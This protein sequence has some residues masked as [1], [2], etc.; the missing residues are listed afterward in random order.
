MEEIRISKETLYL[1]GESIEDAR[2]RSMNEGYEP[3]DTPHDAWY[4]LPYFEREERPGDY[5]V[6]EFVTTTEITK[7]DP[8]YTRSSK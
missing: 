2:F 1:A 4:L 8:P 5:E 6:F 7:V 3:Q